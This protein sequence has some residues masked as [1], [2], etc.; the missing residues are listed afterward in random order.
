MQIELDQ[1]MVAHIQK[2]AREKAELIIINKIVDAIDTKQAAAEVK[3]KAVS[4]LVGKLS[5][6]VLDS[7]KDSE[8]IQKAVQS[9]EGRINKALND[10]LTSGITVK[11]KEF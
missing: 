5:G 4:L 8:L 1:T 11:F 10:M 9:A 2:K 7:I 6:K 3:N